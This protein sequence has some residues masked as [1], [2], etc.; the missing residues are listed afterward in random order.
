VRRVFRV[1]LQA[2]W[3]RDELLGTR[4]GMASVQL[5]QLWCRLLCESNHRSVFVFAPLAKLFIRVVAGTGS[6]SLLLGLLDYLE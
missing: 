2:A 6:T 4:S 5:P 3:H 1:P